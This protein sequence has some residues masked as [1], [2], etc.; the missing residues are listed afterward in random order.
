[1]SISV[2]N[3]ATGQMQKFCLS[4]CRTRIYFHML[5]GEFSFSYQSI[6]YAVTCCNFLII[7]I[8]MLLSL[9]NLEHIHFNET[10]V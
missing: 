5:Y 2:T 4:N 1:M 7:L 6:N 9:S 8:F 3:L 10:E